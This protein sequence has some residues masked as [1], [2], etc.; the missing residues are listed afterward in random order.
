MS[1]LGIVAA[2]PE[3]AECLTGVRPVPGSQ[4]RVSESVSLKSGGIGCARAAC[5]AT[6]L[7][8]QGAK[9]LLS[10]GTAAALAPNLCSGDLIIPARVIAADGEILPV[11]VD[12][13]RRL[14]KGLDRTP[15]ISPLAEVSDVLINPEGKR[16]LAE[17][18]GA[19]AA[20][21]ESAA[22]ARVALKSG[23]SCLVVRV[24]VDPLSMTV[25]AS[26]SAAVSVSGARDWWGLGR[27]LC[28]RPVEVVGVCRLARA[29]AIAKK[30]L[31]SVARSVGPEF[32]AFQSPVGS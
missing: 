17:L 12:W 15:D 8:E 31:R 30:S 25:P 9:A 7:A 19:V 23:V 21:M 5:S 28:R 1:F 26:A 11:D 10:W 20:D 24:V 22:V 2:L 29:F 3:E 16:R 27:G 14:C 4:S 13:H 18:T 6:L 32:L